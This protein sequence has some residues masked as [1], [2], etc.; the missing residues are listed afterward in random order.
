MPFE[1]ISLLLLV[2]MVG[3]VLLSKV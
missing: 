2:A 1:M 3:V